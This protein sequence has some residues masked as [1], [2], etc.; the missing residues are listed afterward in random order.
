[1]ISGIVL[2]FAVPMILAAVLISPTG[3]HNLIHG[4]P[5]YAVLGLVLPVAGWRTFLIEFVLPTA[6]ATRVAAVIRLWV[7]GSVMVAANRRAGLFSRKTG[8]KSYGGISAGWICRLHVCVVWCLGR[9]RTNPSARPCNSWSFCDRMR[10]VWLVSD[11][12]FSGLQVKGAGGA[13]I[14]G[15]QQPSGSRGRAFRTDPTSLYPPRI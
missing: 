2:I 6:A 14:T 13:V 7:V 15:S 1:M 10:V 11:A 3:F 9:F 5:L 8:T 12:R 4:V